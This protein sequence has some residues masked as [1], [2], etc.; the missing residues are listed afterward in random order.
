MR[1]KDTNMSTKTI[2]RIVTCY[3]SIQLTVALAVMSHREKQQQSGDRLY[4]N[5][6]VITPLLAPEGKS[7]E[8]A[9][10]IEK[11]ANS[12]C[13]WKKI[14]YISYDRLQSIL[15]EFHT[16]G[17]SKVTG[18]ICELVGTN[19]A[20]EFYSSRNWKI[21]NQLLMNVYASAEK[22]CYGDGIGIYLTESAFPPSSPQ[23]NLPKS[24]S[25]YLKNQY[26]YIKKNIL[27]LFEP[28]QSLNYQA[29]D[30]GYFSLPAAFGEIPP[31]EITLLNRAEYM[32]IFQHFHE[33]LPTLVEDIATIENL[34]ERIRFSPVSILLTSN[35][36][37]VTGR[38]SVGNEIAAYRE[39]LIEQ[40]I[41]SNSILLIKP[42]PR[43][44]QLKIRQLKF[45]LSDLYSEIF[46]LSEGS[47]FYAPF[48]IFFMRL[49]PNSNRIAAPK[50]FAFSSACLTLEFLFK[51]ECHVGFSEEIVKKYFYSD[52]VANRI[53]HEADLKSALQEIRNLQ[54]LTV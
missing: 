9:A 46:L 32:E 15:K 16:F 50:I 53:K 39:Y 51:A 17:L 13:K 40:E 49:F 34:K 47:L 43:D 19:S 54:A 6:L 22:I 35:F 26:R 8:F 10:S 21:E 44:S 2:K 1:N 30:R 28:K 52:Q 11:M 42:H 12:I 27:S 45:A 18:S 25:S 4:E 5:Y 48:E 29:F 24:L 37:E 3:G 31:M 7:E 41:P 33:Q 36:S 38:M 14:I 20:D 23:K